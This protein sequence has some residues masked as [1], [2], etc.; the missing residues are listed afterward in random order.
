[1]YQTVFDLAKKKIY[2]EWDNGQS[3]QDGYAQSR[4]LPLGISETSTNFKQNYK[5]NSYRDSNSDRW[6]Q[7]PEC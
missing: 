7:S 5:F 4:P 6:I 2:I 1:M 3:P